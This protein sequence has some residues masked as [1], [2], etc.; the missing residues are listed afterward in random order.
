MFGILVW[1]TLAL[2]V[3]PGRNKDEVRGFNL[4][5]VCVNCHQLSS[6]RTKERKPLSTC[7]KIL[8][9]FEFNENRER[10]VRVS[11][12]T[13]AK[14]WAPVKSNI[15]SAR[16][17]VAKIFDASRI[18]VFY[19]YSFFSLCSFHL[20]LDWKKLVGFKALTTAIALTRI[21]KA[22]NIHICY[23]CKNQNESIFLFS[24]YFCK[25]NTKVYFATSI[26]KIY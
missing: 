2:L 20:A 22:F 18:V 15:C 11:S 4:M 12:Q 16:P 5:R 26:F 17:D 7:V 25:K 10:W 6:T 24:L 19:Y 23:Q 14:V 8:D 13:K 21:S 3:T 9:T 1:I